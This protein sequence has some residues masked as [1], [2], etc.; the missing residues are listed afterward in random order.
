MRNPFAR[1]Q[2]IEPEKPDLTVEEVC[3]NWTAIYNEQTSV[4]EAVI[5]ALQEQTAIVDQARNLMNV[6]ARR[7]AVGTPLFLFCDDGDPGEADEL[8]H[9]VLSL[10][11]M[12]EGTELP[13]MVT[14]DRIVH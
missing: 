4:L 8:R 13:P 3:A 5:V 2:P 9:A 1:A 12:L 14:I 10:Q 11:A 7:I 6:M